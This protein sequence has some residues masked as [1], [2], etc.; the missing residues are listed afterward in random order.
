[1]DKRKVT[2][3]LLLVV[4]GIACVCAML[5]LLYYSSPHANQELKQGGQAAL[6]SP[7][8]MRRPDPSSAPLIVR[9]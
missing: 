5:Y 1:M 6:H 4:I 7:S 2:C 3:F 9:S 8:L